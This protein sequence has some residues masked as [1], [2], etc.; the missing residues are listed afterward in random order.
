MMLTA[1]CVAVVS[2]VTSQ[3]YTNVISQ[4]HQI[5][6]GWKRWLDLKLNYGG[7]YENERRDEDHWLYKILI[8][9]E[10]CNTGQLSLWTFVAVVLLMHWGDWMIF[11]MAIPFL[12]GAVSGAIFIV[13]Y[14]KYLYNKW[15]N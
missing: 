14:F 5:F 11:V 4:P 9:C 7:S 6:A 8:G 15:D 10:K 2:A 12:W 1:A 13:A 3:I